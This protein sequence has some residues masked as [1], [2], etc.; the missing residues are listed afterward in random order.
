MIPSLLG[1]RGHSGLKLL[2]HLFKK[3]VVTVKDIEEVCNLSTK[4]AND[5]LNA[6]EKNKWLIQ[7]GSGVRYRS[8]IFEPYIKL[9]E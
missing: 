9:F 6:F 2:T 5:L 8:F 4:A 7:I 3:P 1:R